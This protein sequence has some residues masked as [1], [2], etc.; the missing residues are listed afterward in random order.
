METGVL[1]APAQMRSRSEKNLIMSRQRRSGLLVI[2]V[3][4][5]GILMVIYRERLI[6]FMTLVV[7]AAAILPRIKLEGMRLILPAAMIGIRLRMQ[8]ERLLR[9]GLNQARLVMF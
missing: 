1:K 6:Y 9:F 2:L 7:E 5:A 8:S 4:L 3:Q